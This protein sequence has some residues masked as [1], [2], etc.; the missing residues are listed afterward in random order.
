MLIRPV[1]QRYEHPLF[2]SNYEI[3]TNEI[4]DLYN[5]VEKWINNQVPGGI[6]YGEARLGKSTAIACLETMLHHN[7]GEALPI[8]RMNMTSYI[9]N[10]KTFYEQFLSDVGHELRKGT[11]YEKKE[12]LI[13]L[14]TFSA[15]EAKSYKIILFI[16]EANYLEEK[17]YAWLMDIYNRLMLKHIRL[18]TLLVGTIDI[19]N[20]KMYFI[21]NKQQQL[22]GRFMV[23]EYH[24]HGVKTPQDLQV[25]LASY[26]FM[27]K[28][29][30][31]SEWTYTRYFFPECYEQG[32]RISDDAEILLECFDKI[33]RSLNP[34][35]RLEIPM[36]YVIAS[37]NICLKTY[38]ADGL[39]LE[40]PSVK[41]WQSAVDD[42]GFLLAERTM[43]RLQK[44]I[45]KDKRA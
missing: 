17:E 8:F 30:Y 12:R 14:F 23:F 16:D 45:E 28:Y 6:I 29:P 43:L 3:N 24:F 4:V 42:S 11:T 9:L 34:N 36:Q 13:N 19:L 2:N 40:K 44:E 26:D 10:E 22:I 7:Y 31:G 18:T 1:L 32:Y 38:G 21:Q 33:S 35:N 27:L 41:E 15:L 37:I 39:G 5:N 20:K 25:C